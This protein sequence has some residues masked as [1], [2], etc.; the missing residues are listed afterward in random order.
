MYV[1]TDR[2]KGYVWIGPNGGVWD[3]EEGG[4]KI[5]EQRP[6]G[7]IA[8]VS[9]TGE[10]TGREDIDPF[11][12]RVITDP[13]D[14]VPTDNRPPKPPE[15]PGYVWEW[16]E[17]FLEWTPV[18]DG[19]TVDE[20]ARE[21]LRAQ[22][23]NY[24]ETYGLNTPGMVSLIEQAIANDWS[25]DKFLLEMR[26]SPDY[27][28]NPLFA[29]NM[30]RV[31]QGKRFM[32]E[33]EILQWRD[34]AKRLARQY[35]YEEPSDAYLAMGLQ[36]G[37]SMAEIEHR[38]SIQKNVND[39][40]AGVRWVYENILGTSITDEDLYE[41]FD[42]EFDTAEFDEAYKNALY[43]GRPQALGLGIRSQAEADAFKMLGIDPDEA[44]SRWEKLAQNAPAFARLDAI[45]DMMT[46]YL[47]GDFNPD[48]STTENSALV[49]AAIFGDA[50]SQAIVNNA[51]A[52]EIARFNVGGGVRANQQGQL[53]G[54]LSKGER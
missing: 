8:F 30:E 1:N 21:N 45:D 2:Y 42:P 53:E 16:D 6:N 4:T 40:G 23:Q 26:Q 3:A 27:L 32:A 11:A 35:G 44:Y 7:T 48:L 49:K 51:I 31:S 38:Y 9:P 52:R 46:R 5:G 36:S 25:I 17:E 50:Q 19:A 18:V 37:L 41:I 33:G 24:L 39:M 13:N 14:P 20:N 43:R 12:P 47:P 22:F 54:L 28:A 34:E 29:A 10:R 15:V